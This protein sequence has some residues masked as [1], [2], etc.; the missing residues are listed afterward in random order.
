MACIV[1]SEPDPAFLR[2]PSEGRYVLK[3]DLMGLGRAGKAGLA[4]Y[5]LL[6]KR[7]GHELHRAGAGLGGGRQ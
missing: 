4:E 7:A 3:L 5:D 2:V 1:F 6:G